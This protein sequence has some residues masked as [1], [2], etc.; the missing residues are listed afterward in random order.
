VSGPIRPRA[1]AHGAQR[2][3]THSGQTAEWALAWWLGPAG[4]RPAT[5]NVARV[6][7]ARSPR[8]V[9]ARDA[10]VAASQRQGA[11]GKHQWNP[12]VAPNEMA[13]VG[14]HMRGGSTMGVTEAARR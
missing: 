6:R 4:I 14:A 13:E 7:R 10:T 11:T 3:A 2:P 12:G 9:H 5:G 1:T 8:T